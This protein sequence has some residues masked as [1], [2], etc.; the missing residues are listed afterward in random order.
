MQT[1][2]THVDENGD[3]I[4]V[5]DPAPMLTTRPVALVTIRNRGEVAGSAV[6]LNVEAAMRLIAAL[7]A[8]IRPPQE[9]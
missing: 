4:R 2:F 9:R 7:S 8:A 3:V 6:Y 1:L 5:L